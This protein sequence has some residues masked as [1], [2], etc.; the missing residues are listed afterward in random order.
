MAGLPGAAAFHPFWIKS[1]LG[2][3]SAGRFDD[4]VSNN[5]ATSGSVLFA[6]P[7]SAPDTLYYQCGNHSSMNGT[8][9]IVTPSSPPLV[10]IVFINVADFVTLKSTGT[11]GWSAVP[12]YL[13]GLPGT[14]AAG[15]TDKDHDSV[16][17]FRAD[18]CAFGARIEDRAASVNLP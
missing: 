15:D 11:N 2:F 4:G 5:G 12:E 1:S 7:A 8:L 6:V 16:G 18:R 3:G 13:C 14:N 17:P 10:R 9:T